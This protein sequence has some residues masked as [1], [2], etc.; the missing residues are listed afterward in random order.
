MTWQIVKLFESNPAPIFSELED[1]YSERPYVFFNTDPYALIRA[2]KLCNLLNNRQHDKTE[3]KTMTTTTEKRQRYIPTSSRKISS[4]HSQAVVYIYTKN[5]KP[6]AVAFRGGRSFKP[7]WNYRFPS[8]AHMEHRIKQFFNIERKNHEYRESLKKAHTANVGDILVASW[9]YDQTNIDFYQV[10][11]LRGKTM[12]M[13]RE[14]K[15]DR[16]GQGWGGSSRCTPRK[17]DFASE[18][19]RKKLDANNVATI[20]HAN[21]YP[22]DGKPCYWSSDH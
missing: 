7:A 4:K 14:L 10:V 5:D 19:F 9:G 13:L 21:A 8:E 3:N 1:C 11:E 22:W 6:C 18:P 12:V 20:D 17:D 16:T 2:K 15:Q